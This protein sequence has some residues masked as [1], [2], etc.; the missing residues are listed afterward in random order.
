MLTSVNR[1]AELG[2]ASWKLLHLITLRFPDVRFA[3][4]AV[5]KQLLRVIVA[6]RSQA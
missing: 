1:R 2:R 3:P 5:L 4:K 6:D